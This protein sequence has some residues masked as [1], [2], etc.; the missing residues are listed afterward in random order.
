MLTIAIQAGGK[1]RRMGE[2]KALIPFWGKPLISRV[3]DRISS[4][5][6][7]VIIIT[8]HPENY[9]FLNLP[10]FP[11]LIPGRG[12]L[13]GLYTAL[14]VAS[15]P[16]AAVVACDMP[17]INARLLAAERDLLLREQA[18][19]VIPHSDGGLEPFHAVYRREAC[20]PPI[21]AALRSGKWRVNAW[22]NKV[23]LYVL[24]SEEIQKYDPQLLSFRNVNTPQDLETA[25]QIAQESRSR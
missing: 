10:M 23:N 14:S 21:E 19:V 25:L 24:P 20:I 9:Q 17:F 2:D 11:D 7:E 15:H 13:G 1:S 18:D 12:A 4:T 6:D 8:N 16:V 5:G 22:F 3:V